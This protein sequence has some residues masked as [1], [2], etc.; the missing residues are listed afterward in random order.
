MVKPISF[1]MLRS[2]RRSSGSQSETATP[3]VPAAASTAD[4]MHVGFFFGGH[5]EVEHV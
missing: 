2:M 5:I 1:S 3:G 4:A